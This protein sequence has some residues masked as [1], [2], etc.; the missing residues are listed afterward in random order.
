MVRRILNVGK[1]KEGK[2]NRNEYLLVDNSKG[3]ALHN[4]ASA[5][6]HLQSL[7]QLIQ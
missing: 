1:D 5:F 2:L 6:E 3:T 4:K 7:N